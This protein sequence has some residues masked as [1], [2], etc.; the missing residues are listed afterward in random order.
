V[1]EEPRGGNE[2]EVKVLFWGTPEFAVPSLRAL[3]EEGHEVVGVVTQPDRPAGRGRQMKTS[4]VKQV[5]LEE[6]GYPVLSPE[7]PRGDE[8]LSALRA[9]QPEISVVVAYGHILRAEVL[10][11]P[12]HGSINVH[13]SLLPELRGAAPIN[14][15]IA[16]GHPTSGVT[17]MRMVEAMDAGPILFQVEEAI[18]PEETATELTLRLAERGA[19]A[20]VEALALL[21]IGALEEREQDHAAATHA[22]KV[23]RASARLDWTRDAVALGNHVRGMDE[24]PGAWSLLRGEAIKLFSPEPR[25][26]ESRGG[27]VGTVVAA[28]ESQGVAVQTGAGTLLLREVQPPGKRRMPASDWVRGRGVAVGDRFE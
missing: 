28:D 17:V 6:G 5:A 15:A 19:E 7:K 25:D 10:Q 20:L 23:D 11:L 21:Q 27:A 18:E 24:V 9:L 26:G 16:R 3:A 4:A 1:E 22:P 13:A 14:W 8:F 12:P 2:Q